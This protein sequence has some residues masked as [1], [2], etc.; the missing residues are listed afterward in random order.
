[1]GI[2]DPYRVDPG[3]M[4]EWLSE[5]LYSFE[6]RE[7]GINADA[8]GA[9][10]ILSPHQ[11]LLRLVGWDHERGD[12]GSRRL[13]RWLNEA[14]ALDRR[15]VEE[16]LHHAGVHPGEVYPGLAQD[17]ELE[18]EAYCHACREDVTPIG[19]R[20]PWCDAE[21]GER[22]LRSIRRVGQGR[23]LTDDQVR[24]AHR[25]HWSEG[26]SMREL[27]RRLYVQYGYASAKSCATALSVAFTKL[28][29]QRRDRIEATRLASTTHGLSPRPRLDESA[30]VREARARYRREARARYRLRCEAITNFGTRCPNY[31]QPDGLVCRHHTP[32]GLERNARVLERARAAQRPVTPLLSELLVREAIRLHVRDGLSGERIAEVLL[33]RTR[34]GSAA[35]LARVVRDELKA[36][37][38][39]EGYKRGSLPDRRVAA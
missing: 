34:S 32:E 5:R 2:P 9:Q 18:P 13:H 30:A 29:L 14:E 26:L 16:A 11:R 31:A 10:A 15:D 3:P 22:P 33:P 36:R 37:G 20:C 21:I 6:L 4:R 25:L 1:M 23:L 24:T 27:G 28:A 12:A 39:Y 35:F 38:V 8:L 7:L 19:G 17:V